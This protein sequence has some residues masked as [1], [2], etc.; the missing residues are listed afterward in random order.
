MVSEGLLKVGSC[1]VPLLACS[2]PVRAPA[3]RGPAADQLRLSGPTTLQS[4]YHRVRMP[5]AHEPQGDRYSMVSPQPLHAG[6]KRL[7]VGLGGSL[8]TLCTTQASTHFTC[9]RL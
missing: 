2:S 4:N 9:W 3:A 6:H 7:G 8:P 5:E 1:V